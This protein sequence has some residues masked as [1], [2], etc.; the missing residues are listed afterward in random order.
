MMSLKE[1]RGYLIA[2]T[3]NGYWEVWKL[4]NG[5]GEY[6]KTHIVDWDTATAFIDQII[7]MQED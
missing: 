6:L 5:I 2:E 3:D 7:R 1:Y 4:R